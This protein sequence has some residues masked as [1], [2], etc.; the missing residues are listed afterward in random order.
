[1]IN[2]V[3]FDLDG[4]VLPLDMELFMKIYFTEMEKVFIDQTDYGKISKNIWA[5]TQ[6]VVS[7]VEP[8]SNE[9]VFMEAYGKLIEGDLQEHKR[10][11]DSFYDE[12][13][14]KTKAA[15]V[16]SDW[17]KKSIHIL[18]KKGYELV[19]AT[20][21]IFPL[22]AIEH[23][24]QWAGMKPED[25]SYISCF[26]KNNYCKPQ[27]QYFT[28]VIHGVGKSPKECMMVGN[29]VQ[30]DMIAGKLGLKTFLIHDHIIHR[31]S[32][33]IVAD[34]QGNYENFYQFV[35]EMPKIN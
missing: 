28:E 26:E 20:N 1:M 15:V 18:K 9:E 35:Q 4:T 17:M 25:F 11:F 19:L 22:K 29:D 32:D 31:T 21:P 3:L 7:N 13:F 6:E 33:P 24:I 23:R 30:E 5:A 8:I 27:L 2:T 14:L 10:R 12:G 16:E 34:Y